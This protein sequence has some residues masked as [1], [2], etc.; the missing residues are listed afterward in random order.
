MEKQKSYQSKLRKEHKEHTRDL[1]IEGLIRTM[2]KGAITWS[3]PDVAGEAGV[4][5]AT[6]Y[7]Y[8]HTKEDLVQGLTGYVAQKFGLLNMQPPHTP[9]EYVS[10]IRETYCKSGGVFDAIRMAAVNELSKEVRNE[11]LPERLQ[12]IRDAFAPVMPT[13]Q[14]Q[15]Q[16]HL[17][18]IVLL[19]SSS[20]M[21]R[22]FKHYLDLSGEEA[23][24]TVAWAILKLAYA[25][26]CKEEGDIPSK[27]KPLD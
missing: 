1:I 10:I 23:A 15:E 3:V 16:E 7:R 14:E 9:Q 4:S 19:L 22:A 6:V 18:R 26:T 2:A 5:I 25:G 12:G 20:A 13:F 21:I 17:V 24:E 11:Y 8:F 27:I